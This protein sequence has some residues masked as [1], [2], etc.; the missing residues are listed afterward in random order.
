MVSVITE[1]IYM[2]ALAHAVEPSP[3]KRINRT[4]IPNV[5]PPFMIEQEPP[6]HKNIRSHFGI[7]AKFS[8]AIVVIAIILVWL[9]GCAAPII[10][11]PIAKQKHYSKARITYYTGKHEKVAMG[12]SAIQ[13]QSV[14]AHPKFPFHTKVVIPELYQ[15]LGETEY[16]VQD[17]GSAVTSRKAS[18]G[19][20]DVF[21][22]FVKN[23]S[24]MK[25]LEKFAPEYMVIE[26]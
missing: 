1:R 18:H 13:G 22:I 16:E 17:R 10:T 24:T 6:P 19:Q 9:L 4:Q 21:D 20:S 26:L 15:Y 25:Y 7:V 5:T 11:T 3:V 2:V 14:A 8:L 12:G 23:Y